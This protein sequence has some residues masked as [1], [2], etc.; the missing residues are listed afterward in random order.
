MYSKTPFYYIGL[1]C[2][3]GQD[4]CWHWLF[5]A[6]SFV[7]V[8]NAV[9]HYGALLK[10]VTV[11]HHSSKEHLFCVVL[12]VVFHCSM[13]H[14]SSVVS[15]C[16]CLSGLLRFHLEASRTEVVRLCMPGQLRTLSAHAY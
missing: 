8:S 14:D 11:I 16:V 2:V 5:Q 1:R 7:T 4:T 6:Q 12:P 13:Q 10:Y 3:W 9:A 15:A